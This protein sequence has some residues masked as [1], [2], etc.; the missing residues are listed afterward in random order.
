MDSR[1]KVIVLIIAI[2]ISLSVA[3]GAF[4][5][6]QREH[7][8]NIV[9]ESTLEEL[10]AKQKASDAK[11]SEA[12]KSLSV[13]E[14]KLK[15]TNSQID[16]L[17]NQLQQEKAAKEEALARIDQMRADL[18][19][20]KSSRQ[21][22]ENKLNKAQDD[23]RVI[24]NKVGAIESEKASLELKVKNLEAKA[25]VELGKIVVIPEA[26]VAPQ[27][28][29]NKSK[30]ALKPPSAAPVAK[31]EEVKAAALEG[32]V[33]VLN[34]EYNFLV[35]NLG[36][37]EG[38]AIGDTFGVYRGDKYI[39]DV[40]VEKVQDAMSAAGFASDDVKNNVREGDKV[41][42]KNK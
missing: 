8:R 16:A 10:T 25:N 15:D 30:N 40:K 13:L 4:Y 19:Q 29:D 2:F 3:F 42:K 37:K 17:T 32:K 12:Q 38:V 21:D 22:L 33:L 11:L 34:K 41:V 1:A 9:L 5:L 20:Q 31:K 35:M 6:F 23:L 26:A 18:D 36:N 28:Q 7:A 39:G 14:S 27:V 24:Q